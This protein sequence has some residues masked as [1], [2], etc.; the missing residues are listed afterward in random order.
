MKDGLIA[1]L[2][3]QVSEFY[4]QSLQAGQKSNNIPSD[5]LT[6][7]AVKK[8]H[9]YSA[10]QYRKSRDVVSGGRANNY[11]EEIARL[12]EALQTV[13][14]ALESRAYV[15]KGVRDDLVGLQE[16]LQNDAE[17]AGKD[18]DLIYLGKT[19]PLLS[20]FLLERD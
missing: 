5:W 20:L 15:S 16:V 6:H 8:L 1:R 18:N 4:D 17:R 10:A 19:L 2:A 14:K 7:I 11:G 3:A 12:Q 13:N 9:F